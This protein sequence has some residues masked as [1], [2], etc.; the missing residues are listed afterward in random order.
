MKKPN[1]PDAR[2]SSCPQRSGCEGNGKGPLRRPGALVGK[3]RAQGGMQFF[4]HH[5]HP[6]R[7]TSQVMQ[8]VPFQQFGNH[9]PRM[10]PMG[11]MDAPRCSGI[12]PLDCIKDGPVV[13]V[14]LERQRA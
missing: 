3:S 5:W 9:S 14:R 2:L 4:N 12:A 13:L 11:V 10:R 7:Q 8:A 1:P 6:Q